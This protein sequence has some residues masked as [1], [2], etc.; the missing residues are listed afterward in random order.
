MLPIKEFGETLN[1][2]YTRR[3]SLIGE[4]YEITGISDIQRGNSDP[5]ETFGAQKL[6]ANF[7][8]QRLQRQQRE[9]QRYAKDLIK[10]SVELIAENFSPEM[11]SVILYVSITPRTG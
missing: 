11:L 9:V 4:I 6:K 8:S 3:M 2:L 1:I 5:E 10:L 7:G